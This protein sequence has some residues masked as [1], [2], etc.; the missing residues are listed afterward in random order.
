MK[1][2]N[3]LKL[4][5]IFT[6]S[7]F[8]SKNISAQSTTT[9]CYTDGSPTS[10][11]PVE[12]SIFLPCAPPSSPSSDFRSFY[13]QNANYKPVDGVIS[14]LYVH[15]TIK[16]LF[17]VMQP[18]VLASPK[19]NYEDNPTDKA[20]L[21][22]V[23]DKINTW[24]TNVP[25]PSSPITSVCGTC[26]VTDSRFRVEMA[27]KADGSNDIRFHPDGIP[28]ENI[29]STTS[30][31]PANYN[32]VINDYIENPDG[33]L[34][35]FLMYTTNPLGPLGGVSLGTYESIASLL[36]GYNTGIPF[37]ATENYYRT[38][39]IDLV[40]NNLLHEIGHTMATHHMFGAESCDEADI[41]YLSDAFG[42]STT[43]PSTKNCPL[44]EFATDV[45]MDNN[46]WGNYLTPLQIARWHR[47][48]HF[49]SN[50]KYIYNTYPEDINHNHTG[51][52]QLYAYNITKNESWDFD[53]K[54][55][56][57][58]VVKAGAKLSIKCRVLMPYHSNIIVEPGAELEIDG[59]LIT[60][61]NDTTM[62]YGI[63]VWGD[64]T[65]SQNNVSDQ[66]L[67]TM[68]NGATLSNALHAI[69]L[70]DA[71]FNNSK[72]NG[73]IA[74]IDDAHFVNNR[75]SVSWQ[76]YHNL[77]W[78]F[79]GGVWTRTMLLPNKS[80]INRSTF[81]VNEFMLRD[82]KAQIALCGVDGINI[83]GCSF[84]NT[85]PYTATATRCLS[86][87]PD[88][89]AIAT[90]NA[91]FY[92]DQW[93]SPSTGVI[94]PSYISGFRHGVFGQSFA[95]TNQFSVKN[96]TFE[97]NLIGVATSSVNSFKLIG[98]QFLLEN[99]ISSGVAA[100]GAQLNSSSMYQIYNNTFNP[101][102]DYSPRIGI[103]VKGGGSDYNKIKNNTFNHLNIA[104]QSTYINTD[105]FFDPLAEYK[106]KGLEFLCNNY[107]YNGAGIY[108]SGADI[109][110]DGIRRVQ[111]SNLLPAGNTFIADGGIIARNAY[112]T[113]YTLPLDRYYYY[114]SDPNQNPTIS[115]N[116]TSFATSYNNP[117]TINLSGSTGT[118]GS[119]TTSSGSS[120]TMAAEAGRIEL[121]NAYDDYSSDRFD[122]LNNALKYMNSPYAELERSLLYMQQGNVSQGLNIFNA[123]K[124]SMDL[125]IQEQN[126]FEQGAVLMRI[127]ANKYTQ[128]STP[129]WDSLSQMEIDSIRYVRE[130][131][132]M[133]A[134]QRAC[135]WL[136]FAINE[137]CAIAIPEI[138][139]NSSSN[140]MRRTNESA[141]LN[142]K[143]QELKLQPNPSSN[144][145]DVIYPIDEFGLNIKITDVIGRT[146]YQTA[147]PI[148]QNTYRILCN[149]WAV[150][151]YLY[152][153]SSK[154]KI[155]Y[156]GKFIKQ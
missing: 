155:L 60:S 113:I 101:T 98:N 14:P 148:K 28:F 81:E 5:L 71:V 91:T 110:K 85:M 22:S 152:Q 105:G 115:V 49:M 94:T 119:E 100:L 141:V 121:A 40:A 93:K 134:H 21:Q 45:F 95:V 57:D 64:N 53:I 140:T 120:N 146:I 65:K 33:V 133:W 135:S 16:I 108:I 149:E 106:S 30:T 118:T 63:S 132:T 46:R 97:K 36:D 128:S 58:I 4:V 90:W 26:H 142:G 103:E 109:A 124:D 54:M 18:S 31:G 144:Y 62:W 10:H 55:Y 25:T 150:G 88:Q 9:Q 129:R 87:C 153:V 145:F 154:G 29:C 126:D 122:H 11:C 34:N 77:N 79:K 102:V 112:G 80:Y 44:P 92:L 127:I 74:K 139:E 35:V 1:K 6:L 67:I 42:L 84:I 48:A 83:K 38:S 32:G 99:P 136:S 39:S 89:N 72:R 151:V 61:H 143:V 47:N 156:H 82:P 43:V 86:G 27:K 73:G 114:D 116:V 37:I 41:D 56:T 20:I 104:C 50:R 17:H 3:Y 131:S 7:T 68:K 76:D 78:E 96:T 66:G 130:H 70:Y 51:Q 24:L 13:V 123:I 69:T 75:E 125:T 23:I 12:A 52:G 111:G 8:L 15:K 147:L 19:V 138:P 117:C 2:M 137:S 107:N 59:G